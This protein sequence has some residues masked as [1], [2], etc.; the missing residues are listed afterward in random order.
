MS[1]KRNAV[2]EE[3]R[4]AVRQ[5]WEQRA[6]VVSIA[7]E[8]DHPVPTVYAILDELGIAPAETGERSG[9]SNEDLAEMLTAYSTTDEGVQAI[10][11]RF[12]VSTAQL[13]TA[14][15]EARM[16]LRTETSNKS[17]RLETAVQM[18]RDG[19]KHWEIHE[20]TG[21]SSSKLMNEIHRRR[22]PLRN[23]KVIA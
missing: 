16:P 11:S 12:G 3:V 18:Y 15:R 4:Q 20:F 1:R 23:E 2:T 17:D 6:S 9:P 5:L 21:I 10:C 19:K 22:I 7:E 8:V 13:Y 14:I